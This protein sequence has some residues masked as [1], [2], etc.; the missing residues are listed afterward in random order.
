MAGANT[1]AGMETYNHATTDRKA[2]DILSAGKYC[3]MNFYTRDADFTTV[4]L[5]AGFYTSLNTNKRFSGIR[6]NM[7]IEKR[8]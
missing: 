7:D 6:S 1:A 8:K 5:Y 3:A 2:P 4:K